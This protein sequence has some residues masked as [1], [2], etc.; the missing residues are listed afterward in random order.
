VARLRSLVVAFSRIQEEL[1]VPPDIDFRVTVT[2]LQRQLPRDSQDEIYR[3]GREALVNAVCHSG[4]KQ[5]ELELE[6]SD[7]ELRNR[8]RDNGCGID[9]QVI[10][11]VG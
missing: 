3:I 8:I 7:S 5:V 9:P 10:E 1:E 2:G 6:Y 4:T 11:S